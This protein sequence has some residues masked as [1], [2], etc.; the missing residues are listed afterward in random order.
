MENNNLII[1]H[2]NADGFRNKIQELKDFLTE[3][4]IDIMSINETKLNTKTT[5]NIF[6]YNI[7]RWDRPVSRGGGV[8]LIINNKIPYHRELIQINEIEVVKIKINNDIH[9]IS[10]YLPPHKQL[11]RNDLDKL[12]PKGK[13][14][15][16]LGD[17]NAKHPYWNCKQS[18]KSG[19]V[20]C[21]YIMTNTPTLTFTETPILYPRSRGS[22]TY[23]DIA[24]AS[25][26]KVSNL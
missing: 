7:E 13:R 6:G 8:A 2:W 1:A 17:L 24:I 11:T 20:L 25:N 15:I 3:H 5:I 21:K 9:I 22:P 23:V 10:A 12:L 14:T 18:N 16:I 26:V 4:T 19:K